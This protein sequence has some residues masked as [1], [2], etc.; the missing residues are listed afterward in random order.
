MLGGAIEFPAGITKGARRLD[1]AAGRLAA[2]LSLAGQFLLVG[3]VVL[4]AA[5]IVVGVW[6][7][8][9][10]ESGV[11]NQA[12]S[13]TGLYV[14][15]VISPYLQ[16]MAQQPVLPASQIDVL[17]RA[18]TNT[19]LGDNIVA[20]RVWS[21]DGTVA[22]SPNRQLIGRHFPVEGGLA[23]AVR[24]WP[25]AEMTDLSEPENVFE[26]SRWSRLVEVY[27]PVRE[28]GNGRLIG[29]TEFY[30]LPNDLD[31]A[32]AGARTRSW[33]VVAG[34]FLVTY[35][36]LAGI[37]RRGSD[38]IVRQ[39][40][41]LLNQVSELS[42]LLH[43]N[44]RLRDRVQ[45]A[46]GRTTAI[47]EQ[48]LRR[49]SAD[50]HDGPAQALALAL[51]RLEAAQEQ[52]TARG[53]PSGNDFSIVQGAVSDALNEIRAI[54]A[55]LR[56]PELADLTVA[57]VVTRVVQHH[58]RLTGTVVEVT[59]A[60]VPDLIPLAAKIALFRSLQEALSNATRHASGEPVTVSVTDGDGFLNLEV[61]D[62]GPGFD[63][64]RVGTEGRLGLAGMRE[65]AELL[66]GSFR[67]ETAPGR[68]TL[69]RLRWPLIET[70]EEWPTSSA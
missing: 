33:G 10:I 27:V 44:Q 22:Y 24:G 4:T 62:A 41:V 19:P 15:S 49:V 54:S 36:L 5:M 58:R 63:P 60:Q 29:V 43:Q 16:S 67:L 39:Q 1:R 18:L 37:V 52:S 61:A 50:L 21:L 28:R 13:V 70:E 6:V 45:Q 23:K 34:V 26:R 64:D 66:G 57:D 14:D 38:T 48:A 40:T 35:L 17:D 46:A 9:Q 55:G 51:L 20:F 12:S 56:L 42:R 30:Q 31:R 65:R 47:N 68:G 3:L 69:L 53:S 8:T 7:G 59:V 25:S 2:H 32:I 11:L